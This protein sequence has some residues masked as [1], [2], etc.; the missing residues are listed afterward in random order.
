MRTA[1]TVHNPME[2][3]AALGYL[4]CL[5]GLK[6]ASNCNKDDASLQKAP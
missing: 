6:Q 4:D 1:A 3:S 2:P 5:G